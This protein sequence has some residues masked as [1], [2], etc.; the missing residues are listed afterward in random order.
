MELCCTELF[1]KLFFIIQVLYHRK[2][3][4]TLRKINELT[5]ATIPAQVTM[6]SVFINKCSNAC[7]IQTFTPAGA[8]FS[9]LCFP[10]SGSLGSPPSVESNG[11][12]LRSGVYEGWR[13]YIP[14]TWVRDELHRI[15]KPIKDQRPALSHPKFITS[16]HLSEADRTSHPSWRDA[17]ALVWGSRWGW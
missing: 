7:I 6:A 10:H 4:D 2:W 9:V 13:G 12:L 5:S 3:E 11:G 16:T 8:C 14:G 1:W 15:L 17:S